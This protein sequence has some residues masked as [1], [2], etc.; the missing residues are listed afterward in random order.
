[1]TVQTVHRPSHHAD[2]ASV[3]QIR[4][5]VRALCARFPG[6]YWRRKDREQALRNQVKTNEHAPAEYRADTVRNVDAWYP[7]FHVEPGQ[8]LY[9]APDVRAH[10]W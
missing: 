4:D 5:A 6:E 9:L 8:K 3:G 1:M 10:I 7:T 2:D